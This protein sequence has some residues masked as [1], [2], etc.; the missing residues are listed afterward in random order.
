[1]SATIPITKTHLIELAKKLGSHYHG[2]IGAIIT[3]VATNDAGK[4]REFHEEKKI[5]Y[6]FMDFM[7]SV[8]SAFLDELSQEITEGVNPA[9][10]E[11]SK[12]VN[13]SLDAYYNLPIEETIIPLFAK[14]ASAEELLSD[15]LINTWRSLVSYLP[16]I[17]DFLSRLVPRFRTLIGSVSNLLSGVG[18]RIV[19][20]ISMIKDLFTKI[21]QA[22]SR[23]MKALYKMVITAFSTIPSMML[24]NSVTTIVKLFPEAITLYSLFSGSF[25]KE[26]YF[27]ASSSLRSISYLVSFVGTVEFLTLNLKD[28]QETHTTILTALLASLKSFFM[29]CSSYH[30]HTLYDASVI[31]SEN[32]S[33]SSFPDDFAATASICQSVHDLI[34]SK[35]SLYRGILFIL[36]DPLKSVAYDTIAKDVVKFEIESMVYK[37]KDVFDGIF[38][39]VFGQKTGDVLAA[40]S[41]PPPPKKEYLDSYVLGAV[42]LI[43]VAS[44]TF[45]LDDDEVK[46]DDADLLYIKSIE[47]LAAFTATLRS[48]LPETQPADIGTRFEPSTPTCDHDRVSGTEPDIY[49]IRMERA[50][51][52]LD[53]RPAYQY[54]MICSK[55]KRPIRRK[56]ESARVSSVKSQSYMRRLYQNVIL[57]D[58]ATA[59]T[60]DAMK[61]ITSANLSEGRR[62][63][64]EDSYIPSPANTSEDATPYWISS[65]NPELV[66]L[67]TR[68]L[69]LY[70]VHLLDKDKRL[71]ADEPQRVRNSKKHL[72]NIVD[73]LSL[74]ESMHESIWEYNFSWWGIHLAIGLHSV[75]SFIPALSKYMSD[76]AVVDRVTN[77]TL[78]I[79]QYQLSD[80]S[81]VPLLESVDK[82]QRFQ[83]ALDNAVVA[84]GTKSQTNVPFMASLENITTVDDVL[85]LFK[86]LGQQGQIL[87]ADPQAVDRITALPRDALCYIAYGPQKFTEM[88]PD[89]V[90]TLEK[91]VLHDASYKIVMEAITSSNLSKYVPVFTNIPTE[92]ASGSFTFPLTQGLATVRDTISKMLTDK[93]VIHNFT[94]VILDPKDV[95]PYIELLKYLTPSGQF[96]DGVYEYMLGGKAFRLTNKIQLHIIKTLFKP[97]HPD[98]FS[99][100]LTRAFGRILYEQTPSPELFT[101]QSLALLDKVKSHIEGIS[102]IAR[103]YLV[104]PQRIVE[105]YYQYPVSTTIART[106]FRGE[107]SLTR[108]EYLH[109][110][111][112]LTVGAQAVVTTMKGY[113][114]AGLSVLRFVGHQVAPDWIASLEA[115]Q[116]EEA[117]RIVAEAIPVSQNPD[118]T[119]VIGSFV[120]FILRVLKPDRIILIYW[121]SNLSQVVQYFKIFSVWTLVDIAVYRYMDT[122]YEVISGMIAGTVTVYMGALHL[123]PHMLWNYAIF[124]LGSLSIYASYKIA[125]GVYTKARSLVKKRTD[126]SPRY[127]HYNAKWSI[128]RSVYNIATGVSWTPAF[129]ASLMAQVVNLLFIEIERF[130]AAGQYKMAE[131]EWFTFFSYFVQ[132]AGT[133][134]AVSSFFAA[135][136]ALSPMLARAG[137]IVSRELARVPSPSA[138]QITSPAETILSAAQ[139]QASM[140]GTSE[141]RFSRLVDPTRIVEELSGSKFARVLVG[142]A[143]QVLVGNNIVSWFLDTLVDWNKEQRLDLKVANSIIINLT[144][145]IM[146]YADTREKYAHTMEIANTVKGDY[147]ELEY[148]DFLHIY[149][150]VGHTLTLY[151]EFAQKY[152]SGVYFADKYKSGAYT[153]SEYNR[154]V[155]VLLDFIDSELLKF[156]IET[157]ERNRVIS[158]RYLNQSEEGIK[159][160]FNKIGFVIKEVL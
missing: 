152:M 136:F 73:G 82:A 80:C 72:R 100:N 132:G 118:I 16:A 21:G 113:V 2:T 119:P 108:L 25:S 41:L 142:F 23:L 89:I 127:S 67:R 86:D 120:Y 138:S 150:S 122:I 87:M 91:G 65:G 63:E 19:S 105:L 153:Y 130:K 149:R 109:Q 39:K 88:C 45:S 27:K 62:K 92:A 26:D 53:G 85:R 145:D 69:G 137:N 34:I 66:P 6:N 29:V 14:L 155:H 57:D 147:A 133:L 102:T 106:G 11:K 59:N 37:M 144:S 77:S 3:D 123:L 9:L 44:Q 124:I 61:K 121:V 139:R 38:I 40:S 103:R 110:Q 33:L 71:E 115:V 51:G 20:A 48:A 148:K 111:R 84:V 97:L 42:E 68:A 104:N 7:S 94:N 151:K 22:I 107:V 141:S 17:T 143:A 134:L 158:H 49:E 18:E 4:L 135:K 157:V 35:P 64:L 8:S 5:G 36:T 90:H 43:S 101:Q 10:Y 154:R 58:I 98:Q 78:D 76:L 32:K 159:G 99:E 46:C 129:L 24:A 156:G 93:T 117:E 12:E 140:H 128:L 70:A 96:R 13:L 50:E 114:D 75:I 146:R 52:V 81:S 55:R 15:A 1:M 47:S 160:S 31:I 79:P 60:A 54:E 95:S 116:R 112:M 74:T 30:K 28:T 126:I 125:S 83:S 131:G 56:L